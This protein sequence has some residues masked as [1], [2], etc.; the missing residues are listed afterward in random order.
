MTKIQILFL[1]FSLL[2][3]VNLLL[4]NKNNKEDRNEM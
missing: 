4:K 1:F 2:C 3:M